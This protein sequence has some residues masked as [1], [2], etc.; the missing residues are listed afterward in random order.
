MAGIFVMFFD[1][2]TVAL[3]RR[4]SNARATLYLSFECFV[5]NLATAA[6][7]IFLA[8]ALRHTP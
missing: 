5:W 6:R 3:G 8:R 2:V 4:K 7:S 1:P